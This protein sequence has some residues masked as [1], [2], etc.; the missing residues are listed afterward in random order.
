MTEEVHEAGGR[1]PFDAIDAKLTVFALANGTD[2]SKGKAYRRLEWFTEGFERGILVE[3]GT[4]EAYR[5]T[6]LRWTTGAEDDRTE[7]L[8]GDDVSAEDL[9]A[10]LS[11]AITAANDL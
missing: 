3:T 6:V 2:L 8:V 5:I 7:S 4:S 9:G 10:A 11:A 1:D